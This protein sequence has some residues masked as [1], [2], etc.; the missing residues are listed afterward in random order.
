MK[1]ETQR[2]FRRWW[3][4]AGVLVLAAAACATSLAWPRQPTVQVVQVERKM[5]SNQ[6]FAS[7]TV[8]PVD[9]QDVMASALPAPIDQ[10]R[11]KVGERVQKGDILLTCQ[12]QTQAASLEA[13]QTAVENAQ[14]AYEQAKQQYDSAPPGLQPQFKGTLDQA[15][16]TLAQAKGQLAQAQAAYDATIV[17]AQFSGTVLAVNPTGVTTDGTT[18]PV[19]EVVGADKQ[20]VTSVSEVDAVHI[21]KGMTASLTSDAYPNQQWRGTVSQVAGYATSQT[22]GGGQVEVDIAPAAAFPVPIGYQVDVRIASTTAG[23]VVVVPYEA[24]VQ[25]GNGYSVY[26][27]SQGRVRQTAV[28]LGQSNDTEVQVT[29]GV[30]PGD[31]VVLN[32][33]SLHNGEAVTVR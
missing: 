13:A 23:K 4:V 20:V 21:H 33:G 12:N 29:K 24:L 19:V 14:Q 7:G 15:S 3:W 30:R 10:I 9:Q 32:P 5:L 17:R 25:T 22:S 11:V 28:Q 26:V 27:Y 6:I 31:Q 8:R 16:T 1:Q 2:R 18:V